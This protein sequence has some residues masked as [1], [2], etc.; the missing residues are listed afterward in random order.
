MSTPQLVP[1]QEVQAYSE[2]GSGHDTTLVAVT[3]ADGECELTFPS[4]G[5]YLLTARLRQDAKDSSRANIDVFNVSLL[6]EV[7]KKK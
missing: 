1:G 4:P 3:D 7:R 6:V 2:M 5:M